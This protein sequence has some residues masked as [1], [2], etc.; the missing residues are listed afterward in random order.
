MTALDDLVVN[1]RARA[2]SSLLAE[3]PGDLLTERALTGLNEEF[4][5]GSVA[6][7]PVAQVRRSR[8][9]PVH[10][11]GTSGFTFPLTQRPD[12]W[13]LDGLY[14]CT[15]VIVISRK[16]M[17][18]THIWE[19]PSMLYTQR[20]QPDVLDVLR[21]GRAE[22]DLSQGLAAFIGPGGDFENSIEN[23]GCAFIVTLRARYVSNPTHNSL[24]FPYEVGKIKDLLW[25]VLRTRDV[26]VLPCIAGA[27]QDPNVFNYYPQGKVLIQYDPVAAVVLPPGS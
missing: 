11:E 24:K 22:F 9:N 8:N 27:E 12:T 23:K 25:Y 13:T 21:N 2:A 14:G 17:F 3:K 20:L 26:V 7:R 16:R 1:K 5:L 19:D 10:E 18:M 4:Q 6:T 15:S